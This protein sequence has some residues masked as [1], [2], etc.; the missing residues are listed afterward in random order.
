[1]FP[2]KS[3]CGD[4]FDYIDM[5]NGTLRIAVGDVCGHGLGP[6]LLMSETRACLRSL[7]HE[8]T[9]LGPLFTRINNILVEDM[10][11]S[12]FVALMVVGLDPVRRRLSYCNAGHASGYVLTGAGDVKA[13]LGS[14]NV[15]LGLFESREYTCSEEIDLDSGDLLLLLTDGVTESGA[16]DERFFGE[17]RALETVRAHRREPSQAIVRHVYTAAREFAGR[18]N[19]HDDM[20]LVVCK[21]G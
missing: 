21:L 19:Q 1:V 8:F 3:L 15:P 12:C 4:Y 20:T 13:V 9:E 7:V 11:E 14:T 2:A 18:R 16:S 17:E 5:R 6:A 10:T